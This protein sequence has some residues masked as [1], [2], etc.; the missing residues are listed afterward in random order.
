MRNLVAVC[1]IITCVL[2]TTTVRADKNWTNW[3]GPAGNG[4]VGGGSYPTKW[5]P[6]EN[7]LWKLELPG[8][9]A[10][11]P[12]VWD[13]KIY[14]TSTLEDK[15]LLLCLNVAGKELWRTEVG[16]ARKGKHQKA[17]G[18]NSSPA[19]DGTSVFAYF[20]SGDLQCCDM[21]GKVVW[22]KNLQTTYA[23]DTLWWDLGTSPVLVDDMVI[24]AVMQSGPSYI[25]ALDKK[26]GKE[27]W[28]TDRM[29]AANDESNQAYTTPIVADVDGQSV[30]LTLGADHLTA[31]AVKTGEQ[32]WQ[33]GGFNPTN[34][35]YF[36]TI[37]SPVLAGNLVICPYAR[38]ETLTAVNTA[39]QVSDKERIVWHLD[40]LGTDVPTP[41]VSGNRVYISG[42]KGTVT[43]LDAATGKTLWQGDLPKNRNAF[44]SSPIVA[45]GHVYLTRED[46]ATFVIKDGDKFELVSSNQ[47]DGSTVATPAFVDGMILIRTYDALYCIGSK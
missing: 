16:E 47:V 28:K 3:R 11:T 7:V 9:G 4:T 24:V 18:A 38:G 13:S 14:L 34:H 5:S 31:H 15:N 35:Q 44:S 37:A 45:G 8:R 19:T 40:K 33:L 2:V 6:T 23:E 30:L 22:S 25:V 17:T 29:M 46:G 43:C 36:R 39:T 20:K 21:N 27:R 41:A 10:S 32:L 26:T 42:D 1:L 12:V